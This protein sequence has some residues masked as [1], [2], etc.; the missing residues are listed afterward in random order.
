MQRFKYRIVIPVVVGSSPIGHPKIKDLSVLFLAQR[1]INQETVNCFTG[2]LTYTPPA[3]P[4]PL[5][6]F[7]RQAQ[8]YGAFAALANES[9]NSCSKAS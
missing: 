8:V 5:R 1:F 9:R 7:P 2:N 4:L 6:P 3:A